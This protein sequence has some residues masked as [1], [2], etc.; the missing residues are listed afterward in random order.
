MV[1]SQMGRRAYE[2]GQEFPG[3]R[4]SEDRIVQESSGHPNWSIVGWQGAWP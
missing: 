1:T 3:S 2:A 4:V